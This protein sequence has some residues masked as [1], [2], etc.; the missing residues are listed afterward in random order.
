LRAIARATTSTTIGIIQNGNSLIVTLERAGMN[1]YQLI[2]TVIGP[3]GVDLVVQV[4]YDSVG[5]LDHVHVYLVN[6]QVVK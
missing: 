1:G 3:R 6:G 5:I 2:N 4:T